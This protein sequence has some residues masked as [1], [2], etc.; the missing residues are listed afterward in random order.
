MPNGIDGFSV[1]T[2]TNSGGDLLE[3]ALFTVSGYTN[4][5]I[6][7]FNTRNADHGANAIA[8]FFVVFGH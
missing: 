1:S 6:T 5:T 3:G 2:S 8:P 7:V 4:S